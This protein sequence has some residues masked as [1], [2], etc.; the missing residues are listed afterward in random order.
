[1]AFFNELLAYFKIYVA[2]VV[3]NRLYKKEY[4]GDVIYLTAPLQFII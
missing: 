4:S 1:L 2:I 3:K